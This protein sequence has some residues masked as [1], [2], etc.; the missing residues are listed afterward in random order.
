V[1]GGGKA[2]AT[3]RLLAVHIAQGFGVQH[4]SRHGAHAI[5]AVYAGVVVADTFRYRMRA[6]DRRRGR[7]AKTIYDSSGKASDGG[8]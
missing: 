6:A 8:P 4:R 2:F 7:Q 5:L 3:L 1:A